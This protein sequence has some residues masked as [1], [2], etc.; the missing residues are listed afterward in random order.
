MKFGVPK[1]AFAK[2]TSS[3]NASAITR[4]SSGF[5]QFYS[6]LKASEGMSIL[7]LAGA[8]QANIMFITGA[9]HRISSDDLIGAMIDNFGD[10]FG[11]NQQTE[12]KA[13]RFLQQALDFP[14]ETF[15]GALVWDAF[16]F[17]SPP[18]IDHAVERL[19]RVMRPGGVILAFFNANEKVSEIPLFSYRI[20]DEKTL[21]QVPRGAPQR[22]QMFNNR[23]IEKLFEA[24][25]SVKFFLTRDNLR[26]VLI[27]R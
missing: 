14:P 16:Q 10:D 11:A 19:L 21:L 27:R 13:A 1:G 2:S 4:N 3:S 15:D 5:D 25:A 20:Q 7:D 9:G 22:V 6:M 8:S 17:L 24:S 18:L 26:E 12:A 23:S